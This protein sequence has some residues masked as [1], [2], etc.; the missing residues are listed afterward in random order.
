MNSSIARG[1]VPLLMWRGALGATLIMLVSAQTTQ[2][3]GS[4]LALPDMT[5]RAQSVPE[6]TGITFDA[7]PFAGITPA[8]FTATDETSISERLVYDDAPYRAEIV[9]WQNRSGYSLIYTILGSDPANP[10][11]WITSRVSN[12]RPTAL[13]RRLR[14]SA[15]SATR[16]FRPRRVRV[17]ASRSFGSSARFG[18]SGRACW[19]A[20]SVGPTSRRYRTPRSPASWPISACA[21]RSQSRRPRRMRPPRSVTGQNRPIVDGSTPRQ[22]VRI[23]R[24]R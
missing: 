13:A 4:E 22:Q 2:E 5:T 3:W 15:R 14:R 17:S 8:R 20:M 10:T 21:A 6:E 23:E 1:R 18:K 7:E 19:A 9:Y 24:K 12:L 16:D 11:G